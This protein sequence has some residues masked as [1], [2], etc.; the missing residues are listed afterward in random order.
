[1]KNNNSKISII[2]PIYNAEKTLQKCVKSVINQTYENWELLL[3][4]DCSTDSSLE[5][6]KKFAQ[7]DSRI[8]FY[9][10]KIKK[11]SLVARI[12]GVKMAEGDYITFLDADDWMHHN[13]LLSLN[14]NAVKT[15]ADVVFGA[16]HRVFDNY[17]IIKTKPLN[18]YYNQ[19]IEGVFDKNEIEEKFG[20]SYYANH[21]LPVVN[22]SKIYKK[23]LFFDVVN[24]PFPK[25]LKGT[26]LYLNLLIFQNV[27]KI[28][29]IKDV[30]IYYRDGGI[31]QKLIPNYIE[32]VNYLYQLRKKLLENS[33]KKEQAFHYMNNELANT[34]YEFLID[35]VIVGKYDK[36]QLF[37]KYCEFKK[38]ECYQDFIKNLD[39]KEILHYDFYKN[40]E[41]GNFE[42]VFQL[43]EKEI[44]K[45]KFKRELRRIVGNLLLKF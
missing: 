6:I 19:L 33:P 16:W 23:E 12:R 27:H 38:Y 21:G 42:I 45:F 13:A 2:T 4:N 3:I 7:T 11:Q 32:N 34:F 17:G 29:F 10:K 35:C 18:L 37:D 26:D 9:D 40:L 15:N 5:I 44:S 14:N 28:S 41:K 22:W 8:K 39:T 24:Y 36:N 31:S 30:I 20:Y 43:I 25:I 1:M